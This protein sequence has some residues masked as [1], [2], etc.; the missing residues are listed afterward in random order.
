VCCHW[1]ELR[2]N[3]PAAI[4]KHDVRTAEQEAVLRSILKLIEFWDIAPE[5]LA[6]GLPEPLPDLTPR[7]RVA[8]VPTIK[9][10]HPVSGE[11]WDGEGAQPP[12]IRLA[13]T[14]EGYTVE[15][16]R[17]LAADVPHER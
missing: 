11:T 10:R 17:R 7:R 1:V 4:Q 5:E 3:H 6:T 12:W 15:A 8:V 9:Y 14:Q 2:H 16:L 13:L